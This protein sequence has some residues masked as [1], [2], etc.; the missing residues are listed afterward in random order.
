[1]HALTREQR[2]MQQ[3]AKSKSIMRPNRAFTGQS[4][5]ENTIPYLQRTIGNQA[6]QGLQQSN[7]EERNPVSNGTASPYF[8]YDYS[9]TAVTS[10]RTGAIQAKLALNKPGD[11]YEQEADR[12]A[13]VVMGIS[14]SK[15]R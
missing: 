6:V 10:L 12:V 15:L 1:M 7:S 8:G 13:E 14:E 2:S 11:E 4:R 9:R 5:K 3:E